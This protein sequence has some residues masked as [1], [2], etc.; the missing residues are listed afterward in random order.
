MGMN[1]AIQWTDHTW[2]PWRGCLKLSPGCQQCYMYREQT[3]YGRDPRAVVRAA[4]ATFRSPLR[5]KEPAKVFTCSWSDFFIAEADEWRPEAWDIIRQTPHLTYQIL[6]K[7]PEN[8][9]ERLPEDWGSGWPNVWLGVSAENQKYADRRIPELLKIPAAVH[10]LSA[11]PLLGPIELNNASRE[12]W[13]LR[14]YL[15]YNQ[16]VMDGQFREETYN[17]LNWVI[18]GGESGPKARPMHSDWAR[19]LRDQCTAAGVPFFFK[20]WG[21]WIVSSQ[22]NGI[23]DPGHYAWPWAQREANGDLGGDTT[24]VLRVGKKAAGR[25]L[26]NRE[27]NE[28]PVIQAEK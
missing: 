19:S 2:N 12:P 17:K 14:S 28:F 21:E 25:L 3:R 26:D 7:R 22:M 27:W 1:S 16:R 9:L 20:Q 23:A 4:E 11:E 13:F 6:T 15:T 24:M 8:I 18:V 10:F 5:W